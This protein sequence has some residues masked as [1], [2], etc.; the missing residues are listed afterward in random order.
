MSNY[1][2]YIYTNLLYRPSVYLIALFANEKYGVF[3][4]IA[5]VVVLSIVQSKV[6]PKVGGKLKHL[7]KLLNFF[8]VMVVL[9]VCAVSLVK[10][11]PS[12]NAFF[13]SNS[14]KDKTSP[15]QTQPK[16]TTP[17]KNTPQDTTETQGITPGQTAPTYQTQKQLYY[18]VS[19]SSCWNQSCPRNG[20]SYGGYTEYNYLFYYNL[21]KSC[22]CN[23]FNAQ[24]FWR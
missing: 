24:S 17:Q 11:G 8:T 15:T 14:S 21:C 7:P 6:M 22:S 16:S 9:L 18:S 19:C 2:D 23:S 13:K 20:Y 1:I 12:V 4:L 10:Y 3:I 5:I